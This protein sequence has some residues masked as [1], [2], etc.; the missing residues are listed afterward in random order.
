MTAPPL[1][2]CVVWSPMLEFL[3]YAPYDVCVEL[4]NFYL[5]VFCLGGLLFVS[6]AGVGMLG[7]GVYAV[8]VATYGSLCDG[9]MW[10]ESG[11]VSCI[12]S[13]V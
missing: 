1:V 6:C 4:K 8:G 2:G 12:C 5:F 7:A 9:N 11:R 13:R 3:H 10:G